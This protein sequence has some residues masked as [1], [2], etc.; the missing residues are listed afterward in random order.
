MEQTF[1]AA[2]NVHKTSCFVTGKQVD[3]FEPVTSIYSDF[4]SQFWSDFTRDSIRTQYLCT[5]DARLGTRYRYAGRIYTELYYTSCFKLSYLDYSLLY[6]L[7]IK[8]MFF[9]WWLFFTQKH[10]FPRTT[11]SSIICSWRE[12]RMEEQEVWE[13]EEILKGKTLRSRKDGTR[14]FPTASATHLPLSFYAVPW[15]DFPRSPS[16]HR[17]LRRFSSIVLV[18]TFK[19]LYVS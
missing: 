9:T 19:R 5:A 10:A 16:M 15:I 8:R 4:T 12:K 1:R 18:V 13:E 11:L 6:V 14:S 3:G 7:Y 2:R 17:F